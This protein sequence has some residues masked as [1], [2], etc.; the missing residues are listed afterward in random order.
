MIILCHVENCNSA[1]NIDESP[2]SSSFQYTCRNHTVKDETVLHFQ[3]H[4]FDRGLG[5][6]FNP[7][8]Y[9]NGASFRTRPKK[10]GGMSPAEQNRRGRENKLRL[11]A[12]AAPDLAEN[13]NADKILKIL[14]ED[15]RDAN[16]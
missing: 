15:I 2:I 4:Q 11:I 7:G 9:E 14:T 16:S 13:K 1:I 10:R 6:G 12:R 5:K 8:E 3:D